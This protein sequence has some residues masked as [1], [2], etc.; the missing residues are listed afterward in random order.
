[1][2]PHTWIHHDLSVEALATAYNA[3]HVHVRHFA[4]V[5]TKETSET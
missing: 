5:A 3:L 2:F 1:M 4:C